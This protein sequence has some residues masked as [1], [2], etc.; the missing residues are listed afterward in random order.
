MGVPARY[1]PYQIV[2]GGRQMWCRPLF[3]AGGKNQA[4]SWYSFLP[5]CK[6]FARTQAGLKSCSCFLM[7]ETLLLKGDKPELPNNLAA[8]H[9]QLHNELSFT[10][11]ITQVS[12]CDRCPINVGKAPASHQ[13]MLGRFSHVRLFAT[14]WTVS[15]QAPLSMGFPRQE[16]WSGLPCFLQEIF[17][18][19]GSNPR[20]SCFLH[21]Q[22][23]SLPLAPPGKP[24]II[25]SINK[26]SS[27]WMQSSP[28]IL[29]H[30]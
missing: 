25:R 24:L 22:V 5:F 15:R 14:L 7:V 18:T 30:P 4:V 20:L 1:T 12:V 26:T 11:D 27:N 2:S 10:A 16:Y 6:S 13:C 28:A 21:W 29:T 3:S 17:L 23:S 9:A 8:D 19:Q